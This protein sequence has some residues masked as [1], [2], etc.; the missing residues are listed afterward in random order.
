MGVKLHREITAQVPEALSWVKILSNLLNLQMKKKKK[1]KK[2]SDFA[3][4]ASN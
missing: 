1:D 2:V 4:Q 3:S